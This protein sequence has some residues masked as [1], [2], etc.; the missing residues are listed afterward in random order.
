VIP[1]YS[2]N[3]IIFDCDSTLSAIE[4]I[5]ELARRTGVY[6]QLAPLTRKAMEGETRLEDIYKH[7]LELIKP[8]RGDIEW[9]GQYYVENV[10]HDAKMV[11]DTLQQAG[12]EVHIVSGGILQAISILADYLD[13]PRH[14]LHA[15]DIRHTTSGEYAGYDEAS[16]L[17]RDGGK[18]VVCDYL[19]G[20]QSTAVI[21]GDG[22]TDLEAARDSVQFIGFGG[23]IRRPAV[24]AMATDYITDTSLISLISRLLR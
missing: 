4:G 7:R 21:I 22:M 13:I 8:S 24:E 12:K 20:E 1:F 11:I 3:I 23:V 17:C 6:D 5:D 19:V 14:R 10:V 18:K 2:V 16:P 15:V 9:L